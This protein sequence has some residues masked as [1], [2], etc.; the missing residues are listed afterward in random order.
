MT[1]YGKAYFMGRLFLLLLKVVDLHLGIGGHGDHSTKLFAG[2]KHCCNSQWPLSSHHFK[3]CLIHAFTDWLTLKCVAA[4]QLEHWENLSEYFLQFFLG[5]TNFKHEVK[6]T[7]KTNQR[8][9]QRQP[10]AIISCIPCIP[11]SHL[12]GVSCKISFSRA[13]SH[14]LYPAIEELLCD[15]LTKFVKKQLILNDNGTNVKLK[16][17]SELQS[18]DL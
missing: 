6:E 11:W 9:T 5:Q 4:R 1:K 3:H 13:T 10:I 2:Q 12:W 8:N 16:L 7:K 15:L 14:L 18:I 17:I